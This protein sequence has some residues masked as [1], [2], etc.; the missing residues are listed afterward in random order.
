MVF[1]TKMRWRIERDYQELKQDFG[2]SHYE[3][4]G[5]LGFHH[6]AALIVATYAYLMAQRL[7]LSPPPP[8]NG[9]E[10]VEEK[11]NQRPASPRRP[12]PELAPAH[13]SGPYPGTLPTLRLDESEIKFMTW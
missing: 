5:W 11:I 7:Q 6:H 2:L 3:S 8:R 10:G 1:V 13:R 12:G 4:P 9:S